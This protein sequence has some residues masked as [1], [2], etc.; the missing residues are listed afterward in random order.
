MPVIDTVVISIAFH[1]P[2]ID[3]HRGAI[4]TAITHSIALL[5]LPS[6]YLL[7]P[8]TPLSGTGSLRWRCATPGRS[9]SARSASAFSRRHHDRR[10]AAPSATPA[11]GNSKRPDKYAA[12]WIGLEAGWFAKMCASVEHCAKTGCVLGIPCAP[13]AAQDFSRCPQ[14][15]QFVLQ[16]AENAA[17]AQFRN[18]CN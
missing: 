18:V 9:A 12:R 11:G 4:A 8:H 17:R 2:S 14:S 3:F 16:I 15:H 10:Q 13:N 7:S 5:F 6:G 1:R